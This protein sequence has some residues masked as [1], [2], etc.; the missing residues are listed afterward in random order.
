MFA[1]QSLILSSPSHRNS[2]KI[3][4]TTILEQHTELLDDIHSA[5]MEVIT[6][7]EGWQKQK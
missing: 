6:T 7:E 1:L 5:I 4:N 2:H 3:V